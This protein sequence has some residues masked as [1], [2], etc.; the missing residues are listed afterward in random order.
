MLMDVPLVIRGSSMADGINGK[1]EYLDI[2]D[3]RVG[4]IVGAFNDKYC[5]ASS[6]AL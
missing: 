1:E 4:V 2:G 6:I 3:F 5:V